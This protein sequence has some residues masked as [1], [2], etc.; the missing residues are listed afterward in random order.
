MIIQDSWQVHNLAEEIHK[1]ICK[2]EIF[3]DNL[4]KCK[5][6]SCIQ[7]YSKK[8]DEELKKRFKNTFTF[9]DND[10]NKFILFS[11]KGIYLYEYMDDCKK[12]NEKILPEKNRIL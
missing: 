10:I 7:D 6:L 11:R 3:K 4:I 12:F 2:E 5:S 1:I 8:L 9:S